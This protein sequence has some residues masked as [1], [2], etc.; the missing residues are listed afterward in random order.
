MDRHRVVLPVL[1]PHQVPHQIGQ[2]EHHHAGEA[3]A[4]VLIVLIGEEKLT[5]HLG[6]DQ[7]AGASNPE[8]GD[9]IGERESPE[10]HSDNPTRRCQARRRTPRNRRLLAGTFDLPRRLGV[11]NVNGGAKAKGLYVYLTLFESPQVV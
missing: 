2:G 4:D 1:I 5:R 7:E 3:E 9:D 10:L 6:S 11:Q 8:V